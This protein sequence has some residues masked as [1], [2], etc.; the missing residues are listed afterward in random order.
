[1][2]AAED[3]IE[4]VE[5]EEDIDVVEE[6]Q[7]E[8]SVATDDVDSVGQESTQSESSEES[9]HPK[10]IKDIIAIDKSTT[11]SSFP[12]LTNSQQQQY[13]ADEMRVL[14]EK[15]KDLRIEMEQ[16][17]D[18]DPKKRL[19]MEQMFQQVEGAIQIDE[20][21]VEA[22]HGTEAKVESTGPAPSA[23]DHIR[24]SA[25]AITGGTLTVAGV[26]LIP[27]P[28]IPG[29]LVIYGGLLVLAT[30]FEAAKNALDTMKEPLEQWLA[31]DEEKS[32][33]AED[34]KI[35]SVLW[36]EMIGYTLG[37]DIDDE[38]M[39][40]IDPNR[41]REEDSIDNG[42]C[43]TTDS[44]K[45]MKQFLRKVLM[46]DSSEAD[47]N[48]DERKG[49]DN[50]KQSLSPSCHS[51]L[52]LSGCKFLSFDC[53]GDGVENEDVTDDSN[54]NT[55]HRQNTI[56]LERLCSDGSITLNTL[57]NCDDET[58]RMFSRQNTSGSSF[59]ND[60]DCLWLQFGCNSF[61]DEG[62]L[63]HAIEKKR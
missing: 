49:N 43:T 17:E 18:L 51:D 52:S 58:I 38:F 13:S 56:D 30:E 59:C 61:L 19:K 54:E 20:Q 7:V 9:S 42:N 32:D 8:N 55:Q 44:S 26:A 24:R 62:Q 14:Q 31:D 36:E 22:Q 25:V 39:T 29:F 34:E 37:N 40:L 60:N 2:Q 21:L 15:M 4:L 3:E 35:N 23:I 12:P 27:C 28:I 46:L 1:M 16:A 33:A 48:K 50:S 57:N 11:E 10:C 45:A 47:A 6:V 63:R 5:S 41:R 53:D